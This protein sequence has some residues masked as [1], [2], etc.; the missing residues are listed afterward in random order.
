[1]K[2]LGRIKKVESSKNL[3]LYWF[4]YIAL[5]IMGLLFIWLLI[6]LFGN[7]YSKALNNCIDNGHSVEYCEVMLN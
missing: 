6:V 1:M 4:G 7:G 2:I 3:K 5:S